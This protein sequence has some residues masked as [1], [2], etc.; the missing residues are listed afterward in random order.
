MLPAQELPYKKAEWDT[1]ELLGHGDRSRKMHNLEKFLDW[2]ALDD[3]Y[4]SIYKVLKQN[5]QIEEAL[6]GPEDQ[7]VPD[8]KKRAPT[9]K[10]G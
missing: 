5:L 9:K 6:A 7:L 10:K 4:K 3:T 2:E 8:K 1:A